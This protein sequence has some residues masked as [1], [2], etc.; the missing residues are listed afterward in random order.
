MKEFSQVRLMLGALL[1]VT[2]CEGRGP[3][4]LPR[5]SQAQPL[6]LDNALLFAGDDLDGD[7][8]LLIADLSTAE[9]SAK[10]IPAP[11]GALLLRS[12]PTAALREVVGLSTGARARRENGG[13]LP[14]T[15]SYLLRYDRSG[16]I[17]RIGLGGRFEAFTLSEDGAH[18]VAHAPASGF[19]SDIVVADLATRGVPDV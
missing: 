1:L 9:A 6:A 13:V 4:A 14:E 5:L 17:A 10:R 12:R 15:E 11:D 2:A 16:E 7:N 8:A 18:V 19:A 3:R